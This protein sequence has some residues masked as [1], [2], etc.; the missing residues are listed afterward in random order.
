MVKR[1]RVDRPDSDDQPGTAIL[2]S[3]EYFSLT[4]RGDEMFLIC[5]PV[6][7]LS[8]QNTSSGILPHPTLTLGGN[9]E[10]FQAKD[11]KLQARVLLQA[12]IRAY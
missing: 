11:F 12:I 10:G 8:V 4:R 9:T 5:F 3:M 2:A 1:L 6:P 7:T